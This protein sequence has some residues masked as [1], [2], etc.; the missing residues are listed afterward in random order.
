MAP[1]EPE[2]RNPFR[3]EA[4]AFRV[5]VIIVVAAAVVI[6]AAVLVATWLGAVLA[7]LLIGAGAYAT[8]G[9]LRVALSAP[10]ETEASAPADAEVKPEGVESDAGPRGR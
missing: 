2:I 3:S 4:D 10:A 8:V 1:E 5:L 6:A 9:W 7:M